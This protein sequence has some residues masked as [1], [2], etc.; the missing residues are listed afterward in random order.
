MSK[1]T[2]IILGVVSTLAIAVGVYYFFFYKKKATTTA[3]TTPLP[4]NAPVDLTL[5]TV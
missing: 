5:P 2:K 3:T 1:K 4:S